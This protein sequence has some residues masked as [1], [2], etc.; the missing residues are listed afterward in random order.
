MGCLHSGTRYP[1]SLSHDVYDIHAVGCS[2]LFIFEDSIHDGQTYTTIGG[3]KVVKIPNRGYH[4]GKETICEGATNKRPFSF[5]PP[6]TAN[7]NCFGRVG[8]PLTG[9]PYYLKMCEQTLLSGYPPVNIQNPIW[10]AGYN[11]INHWWSP[12]GTEKK[13]IFDVFTG[14]GFP[15][16]PSGKTHTLVFQTA[17]YRFYW[18]LKDGAP[19]NNPLTFISD[20]GSFICGDGWAGTFSGN[21]GF[22]GGYNEI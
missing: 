7:V 20:N 3:K 1:S 9:Y 11:L 18:K 15:L 19:I 16:P 8:A 4:F 6:Y 12:N 22:A 21:I 13:H 14:K 2:R 17:C 5:P 10:W